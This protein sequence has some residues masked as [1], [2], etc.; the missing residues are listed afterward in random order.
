MMSRYLKTRVAAFFVFLVLLVFAVPLHGQAQSGKS[1]LFKVTSSGNTIYLLGSMHMMKESVYP[2]SETIEGAFRK[3]SHVVF[4]VEASEIDSPQVQELVIRKSIF[5]DGNTLGKVLKPA[6]YEKLK[7]AVK[8]LGL[9][10]AQLDPLKP[11]SVAMALAVLKMN[12]LGFSPETGVDRHFYKKAVDAGKKI[13][14]LETMELQLDV[15]D[16]LPMELQEML[17]NQTLDDL[18]DMGK[19]VDEMMIVWKNGDMD[20]IEK[21]ITDS[22]KSYPELYNVIFVQRNKNWASQVEVLLA[23]RETSFVVVGA[24]HLIGRDSLPDLLRRKGYAVEQM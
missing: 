21:M 11:W 7:E 2:L 10:I 1:C 12:E 15:M 16:G 17:M 3:S 9:D 23:Q 5:T 8:P 14:G 18:A 19:T 6:T 4:E 24:G 13:S 20:R 22:F